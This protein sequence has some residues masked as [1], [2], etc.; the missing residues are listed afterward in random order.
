LNRN[1][2]KR[3]FTFN[4]SELTVKGPFRKNL[5]ENAS[6]VVDGNVFAV[7]S[8]GFATKII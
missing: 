2:L 8:I 3:I 5:L 7:V 6:V 1:N 4:I